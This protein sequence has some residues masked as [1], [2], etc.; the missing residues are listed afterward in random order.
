MK[1]L[2]TQQQNNMRA[3]VVH[4]TTPTRKETIVDMLTPAMMDPREDGVE[5]DSGRGEATGARAESS[6][7]VAEVVCDGDRVCEESSIFDDD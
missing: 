4:T 3:R 2:R 7:L 5:D 1:H 6:E